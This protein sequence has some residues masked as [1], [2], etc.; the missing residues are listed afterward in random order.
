MRIMI[1]LDPTNK[2]GTK[3]AYTKFR[4]FLEQDG[5]FKIQPLVYCRVV[6]NRKNAEKHIK[7]FEGKV[8]NTGN[9]RMLI[10]SERQYGEMIYL[11]GEADY[12]EKVVGSKD[13]IFL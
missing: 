6:C 12:Q 1:L 5:Y 8:P 11:T 9:I 2:Y 4:K 10:L 13:M 7:R 3:T